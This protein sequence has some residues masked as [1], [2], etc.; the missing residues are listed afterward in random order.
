MLVKAFKEDYDLKFKGLQ[1]EGPASPKDFLD[2]SAR[3]KKWCREEQAKKEEHT[4]SGYDVSS[5]KWAQ[6]SYIQ[7]HVMAH[8]L[9]LFDPKTNK[10][11]VDRYLNDAEER[12]GKIDSV[13]VWPSFAN[14]GCDSR[15]TEDFFRCLPGGTHGIRSLVDE[16]HSRNIK[17][18]FPVLSW[19]K[20][21]RDPQASWSYILPRLFKEFN[22]DGML[23]DA[24]HFT[25]DYWMNSLAIGHPLVYQSQ[26]SDEKS[27]VNEAEIMRWNTVSMVKYDSKSRIPTV[28]TRK[29]IEPKHMGFA[30]HK[31][32]RNKTQMIQHAFFNG[33][34]IEM[35]ENVFGTWNQVTP[36]DGEALRRTSSILR[37]F[38]SD[39]LA[40]SEWEPH[41][42]CVRWESVYSSKFR[43][44][45][46]KEQLL[47]TF[48]NKGPVEAV[49]HQIVVNYHIGLQF[50]DVWRGKEIFPDNIVDGLATISFD[51]EA[52]GYGCI[53]ATPDVA[54]LPEGFEILLKT[55]HI[56]SKTSLLSY[57]IANAILWQELDQVTVSSFSSET[58]CGMV[59]IEGGDFE[60]IVKGLEEG[61]L[62]NAEYPGV[63]VRYPW[64]YQASR[65][66][67]P[68]QMRLQPFYIDPYPVTESE[69]KEFMDATDYKPADPTNFLKHWIGGCYPPS[70][71]NK[72]V[73]H[74]SIEDARAYAAWA[75]KRLPHEW[76]WQ[77]VAQAG[78]QYR[79]YPWGSKWDSNMVP[80]PYTGRDRLYPDHPPADVDANV[81]GRSPFGVYDLVGNV[82][83]WTDVY[84]DEHSR[85]A[86]IRGGSYYKPDSN[87]YFPQAY[88]NDEHGKYL[89]MSPSVDRCGTIGFRCVKDTEES[90]AVF[91]NCAF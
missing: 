49:G 40:N 17:V 89:L 27:D 5:L 91:G 15:N 54:M 22:V 66:H 87:K 47:W 58:P 79:I 26:G 60:F 23:T 65:F 21:T 43:H 82:W 3:L 34:G 25:Q 70:R 67:A 68:Y 7:P 69:F 86:I 78:Q 71:A 63:D 57:P 44:Y 81:D 72:P 11:T 50:Y 13:V 38:G 52:H 83:Q 76:E 19:D 53:F 75:G 85:A 2:W 18:V 35:W 32:C 48:I 56:C 29:L 28:A 1:V 46:N 80:E 12:Y 20:G 64:E 73:T 90:A 55:M 77:Y 39:F 9:F 74:V 8:D 84:V 10:Y 59:R 61:G 4:T 45:K 33:I 30:S 51:I 62:G 88:R 16:F 14:L 37:C 41:C 24:S 42:P 31:W 6:S 36:R